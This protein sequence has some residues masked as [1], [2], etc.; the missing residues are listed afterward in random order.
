[1]ISYL[2]TEAGLG[3]S[4]RKHLDFDSLAFADYISHVGHTALPTQ[5]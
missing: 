4:E 2:H 3:A 1:M 5:F